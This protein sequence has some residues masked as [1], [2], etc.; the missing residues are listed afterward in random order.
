MTG[1]PKTC[2]TCKWFDDNSNCACTAHAVTADTVCV[3]PPEFGHYERA[4]AAEYVGYR[5]P[6]GGGLYSMGL[7]DEEII[8]CQDCAHS[9]IAGT[10]LVCN[11]F[12]MAY[13]DSEREA[14]VVIR[15]QVEPDGFCAW[16][17]RRG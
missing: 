13:W 5:N 8:R 14:E 7:T 15:C 12:C 1:G 10:Q 6:I 3:C 17:K 4:E 2:G 9:D 11:H 16:G